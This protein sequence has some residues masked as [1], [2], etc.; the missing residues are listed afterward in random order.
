[1]SDD[2]NTISPLEGVYARDEVS[3]NAPQST[4]HVAK[5]MQAFHA[6]LRQAGLKSTSQRDV[7]VETFFRLNK[8]I[9]ADELLQEVNEQQRIGYATV[10]RTL[11]LLVDHGF[12]VEKD[13][14]DNFKRYDPVHDQDP[15][16]D[17]LICLDCDR[18]IEFNDE[19]I[20]SRAAEIAE[21]MN[22]TLQRKRIEL[23]CS[24]TRVDDCPYR[25]D[26][27]DPSLTLARRARHDSP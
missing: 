22:F 5:A 7:I 8:H 21:A 1:M 6:R 26:H 20:R 19:V 13:F 18:V 2:W 14:G 27:A 17:H 12:A 10:Y 16:H 23:Y 25:D 9:S 15:W 11:G 4:E 24:C 3:S